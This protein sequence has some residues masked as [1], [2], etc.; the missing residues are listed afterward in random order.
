MSQYKELDTLNI[1]I[2]KL[3]DEIGQNGTLLDDLNSKI[4]LANCLEKV[5][6]LDREIDMDLK[7]IDQL[8]TQ[9]PYVE[10]NEILEKK[11]MAM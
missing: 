4:K 1:L 9:G 6:K 7:A 10:D 2:K 8:E 3:V 11:F 5:A